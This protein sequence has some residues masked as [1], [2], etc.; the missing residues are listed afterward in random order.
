MRI[1]YLKSFFVGLIAT[2]A[3]GCATTL[4]AQQ[5]NQNLFSTLIP[6]VAA[7]S[8]VPVLAPSDISG[9]ETQ[10]FPQV[11]TATEDGYELAY[12]RVEDCN[13]AGACRE[14]WMQGFKLGHPDFKTESISE[15]VE[16]R[17]SHL[18]TATRRSEDDIESV[19]LV[20][21]TEAVVLPW[22]GY[23]HPGAT[24]VLFE[25]DGYQYVFAVVM[26][27]NDYVVALAN[28]AVANT[29]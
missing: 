9:R 28:S 26:A 20:D 23:A 19:T 1:K 2:I 10:F 13:N 3:I 24:E 29:Q 21:G 17:R 15:L 16:E 12:G 25:K 22:I 8:S 6:E 7:V 14:G 4:N 18:P 5:L 11:I 27:S